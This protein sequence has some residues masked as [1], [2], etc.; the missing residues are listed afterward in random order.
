MLEPNSTFIQVNKEEYSNLNSKVENLTNDLESEREK[1]THLST[2]IAQYKNQLTEA[3]KKESEYK[4]AMNRIEELE[5]NSVIAPY[6]N[7]L[8]PVE[9][10]SYKADL[11]EA[12][13]LGEAG[14]KWYNRILED[15]QKNP[16][17]HNLDTSLPTSN[18]LH[19]G[20][21]PNSLKAQV[22][23]IFGDKK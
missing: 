15:M 1:N 5:I 2:E 13:K 6:Q 9:I 22:D 11:L 3:Q 10:E 19:T 18:S 12:K 23:F 20:D 21:L 14:L 16:I 17:M 8:T 7:K 4:K